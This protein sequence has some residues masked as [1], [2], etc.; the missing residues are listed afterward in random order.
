[1]PIKLIDEKTKTKLKKLKII[2]KEA[3]KKS[4]EKFEDHYFATPTVTIKDNT[5]WFIL[6]TH[7]LKFALE[8]I[9][10]FLKLSDEQI[11]QK[12][13]KLSRFK[14]N[15][16]GTRKNLVK[17]LPKTISITD[18]VRIE[19]TIIRKQLL[20]QVELYVNGTLKLTRRVEHYWW[21]K[22]RRLILDIANSMNP[23]ATEKQEKLNRALVEEAL[24]R[25]GKQN[26]IL[27]KP[28][29]LV[30]FG[31]EQ[32]HNSEPAEIELDAI[33]HHV[34]E[35][36]KVKGRVISVIKGVCEHPRGGH[37]KRI[38]VYIDSVR[39]SGASIPIS[40][41]PSKDE[42]D[43]DGIIE[44]VGRVE[45]EEQRGNRS[46]FSAPLM[47][48]IRTGEIKKT[49]LDI[50]EYTPTPEDL[51]DFQKHFGQINNENALVVI[52]VTL[53]P[54]ITGRRI[55]KMF[56]V[57]TWFSPLE[58]PLRGGVE[59]LL[60]TLFV[61]DPRTG[62]DLM[63]EDLAENLSPV[64]I[65]INAEMAKQTGLIGACVRDKQTG[66]W[67]II[68]GRLVQAD[69]YGAV[70]QGISSYE[71]ENLRQMREIIAKR[72]AS[73]EKVVR[74]KKPCRCRLNMSGNCRFDVK[75]Y[76]TKLQAARD[77]GSRNN[78]L[79]AELADWLRIHVPVVFDERD[80][81]FD[82]IDQSLMRG[83]VERLIP[84]EIF[85]KKVADT[86]RRT[87]QD[88]NIKDDV[89]KEAE[90]TLQDFR[91]IYGNV[92][93][94]MLKSEGLYIF[95][96]HV[97][98][99]ATLRNSVDE[100]NRIT[101]EKSDVEFIKKLWEKL[102]KNL[103]LEVELYRIMHEEEMA[104]KIASALVHPELE[105]TNSFMKTALTT[106]SEIIDLLYSSNK[107]ITKEELAKQL[108][109]SSVSVWS[110]KSKTE[111]YLYE[112][113]PEAPKLIEGI[114]HIGLLLT[115]FGRKVAKAIEKV[116]KS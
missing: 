113:E 70:I 53:A 9:D 31:Y 83:E 90:K 107:P 43:P 81:S 23:K 110:Y 111:N 88:Y 6:G 59:F 98:A 82:I 109:I 99:F 35:R 67:I 87:L 46:S 28:E 57:L 73:I 55:G 106:C 85:K 68:W 71:Q 38:L 72:L 25:W 20:W 51:K 64:T 40:H 97:I 92:P 34:G 56:A 15:V 78:Q 44:V 37:E 4:I 27:S 12:L 115:S 48:M 102:F 108:A 8:K 19:P 62:K 24:A 5:V 18:S 103:G 61:G 41:L 26:E 17:A 66:Q 74:G 116:E 93:I 52:D 33:Y 1:M 75:D 86:W 16:L 105:E 80:V 89:I 84:A 101:P 11:S 112:I 29:L 65:L 30:K 77:V 104:K 58:L 13:K 50:E 45:A 94:A 7:K 42:A 47:V 39:G 36:V 79:Y 91:K 3:H 2:D 76:K 14:F 10:S 100:Q 60:T 54:H 22:N 63:L 69:K 21:S 49:K 96:S 32:I 114:P 95:L